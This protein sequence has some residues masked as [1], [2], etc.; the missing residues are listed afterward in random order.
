M[1]HILNFHCIPSRYIWQSFNKLQLLNIQRILVTFV[2]F[3]LDI[4]GKDFNKLQFPN[5]QLI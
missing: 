2:V 1:A 5:I 4:S 3:Q